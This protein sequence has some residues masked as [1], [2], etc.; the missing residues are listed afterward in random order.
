M[1]GGPYRT[2]QPSPTHSSCPRPPAPLSSLPNFLTPSSSP[3]PRPITLA[4]L[5]PYPLTLI[6]STL[7]PPRPSHRARWH[8]AAACATATL[9]TAP[10]YTVAASASRGST[11]GESSIAQGG[12]CCWDRATRSTQRVNAQ[13]ATRNLQRAARCAQRASRSAQRANAQRANAKRANAG[14]RPPPPVPRPDP[15]PRYPHRSD[16][17]LVAGGNSK[18]KKKKG[19]G[20][21]A[22]VRD[23]GPPPASATPESPKKKKAAK[24]GVGRC[25][26]LLY[27]ATFSTPLGRGARGACTI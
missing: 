16:E 18:K 9:T 8:A 5:P 22:A 25:S 23:M 10:P 7:D 17:C 1:W 2:P 26:L 14:R 4:H 13:R 21:L 20:T 12:I 11:Y 19:K 24:V 6:F 15:D 27:A 3:L